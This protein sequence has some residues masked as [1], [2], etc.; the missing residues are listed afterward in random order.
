VRRRPRGA[1]RERWSSWAA[2]RDRGRSTSSSR[3]SR[4]G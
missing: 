4:L 2:R 3:R 1:W